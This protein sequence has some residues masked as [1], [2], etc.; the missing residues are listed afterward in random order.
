VARPP[1]QPRPPR[2]PSNHIAEWFGHR[3][4]PDVVPSAHALADQRAARC[5][6]LSAAKAE[7]TI[8]IKSPN[9]RGVC[10]VST[11]QPRGNGLPPTRQDWLVCP[12][13]ALDPAVLHSCVGLLFGFQEGFAAYIIPGVR[14][15]PEDSPDPQRAGAVALVRA[16][17]ATR[18]GRGERVFI[19]FDEKLGGELSIPG[20]AGSPEF[21][22]DVT[23][24]EL[25]L[26]DGAVHVDRFGVVEIQTMDFH[27]SYKHAVR[28]LTDALRMH[29][30]DFA[31]AVQDSPQWLAEEIEGPNIANVFK[32][33]FYQMMFKFQLAQ[34]PMCAGCVMAIPEAVWDSWGP[35]LADPQPVLRPDGTYDLFVAGQQRPAAVPAWVFV[36][37]LDAASPQTPSPIVV[38][39]VIATDAAAISYHALV[40]APMNSLQ[41][42]AS[43]RGMLFLAKSR[44]RSYWPELAATLTL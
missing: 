39:K 3:V 34:H 36:F 4:Y 1:K 10:T 20:T 23:V 15:G 31:R 6:F 7:S 12:Y 25:V 9:A 32:R 30:S 18:L 44:I 40:A 37:G 22:F 16:D 5:P 28:N 8:C 41:S 19:Y 17:V 27:G 35:H 2:P 33:T 38:R 42:V 29:P 43:P 11:Q 13:R 26:R 24:F 14:L 21:S